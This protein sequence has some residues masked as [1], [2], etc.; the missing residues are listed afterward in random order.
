MATKVS[1]SLS[2]IKIGDVGADG[3]MGTA[4]TEFVS[5][6]IRDTAVFTQA[7]GSTTDFNTEISDDPYYS[8]TTPGKKTITFDI[9]GESVAQLQQVFGGTTTAGTGG[10]PDQWDAPS[11]T[12]QL[13]QSIEF[14]HK[15]GSKLQFPRVSLT[16]RP[17]WN[18][19]R[20]SLP[21]IHI[22]MDV[23]KPTKAGVGPWRFID[24]PNS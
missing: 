13:E 9:Y 8:V 5:D 24:A 16:A 6:P 22:S 23:L 4:L 2:A 14:T 19:K 1:Y 20:T 12:I 3:G 7:D 15:S 17:E 18:F 10:A 11:D 21:V